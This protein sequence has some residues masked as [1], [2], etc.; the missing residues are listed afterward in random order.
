MRI[1]EILMAIVI[2]AMS[3]AIMYKSGEVPEW[4]G[5]R[6]SNIWFDDTGAPAGGFWPF[7][8]CAVMFICSVWVLV[9]GVLRLSPPSQSAEPYLD[10]HGMG[11]LIKVGLPVFMLVL[12]TNYIS[13]YFSMALFMF[14]YVAVLGRHGLI[15]SLAMALVFPFWMYLFFDITMTENLPKGMLAIED[16]FYAPLGTWMRG[17]GGAVISLMFVAAGGVLVA[18]SI[19]SARL[20]G[21]G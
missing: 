10:A 6:F 17:L 12:L 19:L 3:L 13:M 20:R 2:A 4:K 18:A 9:N 7:W 8:V 16:G 11:V 15:L 21:A 1:A 5:E 14:Y